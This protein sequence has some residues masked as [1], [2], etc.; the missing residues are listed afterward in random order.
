MSTHVHLTGSLST[1]LPDAAL[2]NGTRNADRDGM[3]LGKFALRTVTAA[4]HRAMC[5]VWYH[6]LHTRH[7][8][9]EALHSLG[10]RMQCV[11]SIVSAEVVQH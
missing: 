4:P 1:H 11:H 8:I 10:G 3:N 7:L 9:K 5:V 2:G 6:R